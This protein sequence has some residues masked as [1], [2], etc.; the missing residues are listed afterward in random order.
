MA[1]LDPR[2]LFIYVILS[3]IVVTALNILLSNVIEGLPVIK[4]GFFFV[5]ILVSISLVAL[6]SFARDG[7]FDKEERTTF[8]VILASM[9][10]FYWVVQH[11]IP[12]IFSIIPQSTQEVFNGLFSAFQ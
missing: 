7:R 8:L 12:Q 10:A 3:Y 5:L 2:D 4:S 9:V 11:F 1:K 6:F